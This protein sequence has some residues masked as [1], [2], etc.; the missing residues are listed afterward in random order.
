MTCAILRRIVSQVPR[1]VARLGT[2]EKAKMTAAHATT[3]SHAAHA[4]RGD[5]SAGADTVEW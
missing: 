1:S 4:E 2:D 5:V 3:G